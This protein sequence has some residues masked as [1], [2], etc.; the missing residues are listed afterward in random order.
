MDFGWWITVTPYGD[1]W[2]AKRKLMHAHMNQNVVDRYQAIQLAAVRRFARDI[3]A[4]PAGDAGALPRA[5]HLNFAQMIMK[6]VY[7]LDIP[8]RSSEYISLPED[9]LAAFSEA[10][11]PGRY[12]VNFFPASTH[13]SA[14]FL[15]TRA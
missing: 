6:L 14:H 10:Y 8:D 3:L 7:G 2:R 1:E 4:T 11:V 9:L 15:R 13:G 12:L 5:V